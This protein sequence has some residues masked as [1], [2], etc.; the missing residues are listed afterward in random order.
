[1]ERVNNSFSANRDEYIFLP[2]H[3]DADAKG[4]ININNPNLLSEMANYILQ[5]KKAFH[6]LE[7]KNRKKLR[8][9]RF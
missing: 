4:Y 1:M 9:S 3:P 5:A 8:A 2:G 6:E 7:L